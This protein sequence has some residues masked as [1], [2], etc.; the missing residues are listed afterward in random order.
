MSAE[1]ST[2]VVRSVLERLWRGDYGVLEEHPGYWETRQHFPAMH[3]A[4]PDL[5]GTIQRQIAVGDL[6]AT[7]ATYRATHTGEWLGIAPT[8]KAVTFQGLHLDRVAD[9]KV[10]HHNAEIGW[11]GVL[12]Q[13]GVLPL[14]PTG[15]A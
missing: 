3:A 7:H 5:A 14:R 12:V 6:V 11:F 4:F 9:G 15:P 10:V 13:L 1:E 8:G 2:A